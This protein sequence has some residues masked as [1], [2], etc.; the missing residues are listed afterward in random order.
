MI[1][2]I[3]SLTPFTSLAVPLASRAT[4]LA[5]ADISLHEIEQSIEATV[6]SSDKLTDTM[7]SAAQVITRLNEDVLS[8]EDI[9]EVIQ[10]IAEQTNLLALNAAIEAARAG[11]QG[12]GFAVVADEVRTLA[13]RTQQSTQEIREK[14]D[15][16]MTGSTD[17]V[18]SIQASE[19]NVAEVSGRAQRIHEMFEGYLQS[20]TRLS[21]LNLQVSAST[22]QQQA[23][24]EEIGRRTNGINDQ[25]TELA[26]RFEST[27][28]RANE[29]NN[30]A[31]QLNDA[32]A[33]IRL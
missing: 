10:K 2:C 29:L 14:I 32:I 25:G 18:N 27:S 7:R 5:V 30:I 23:T 12:R 3:V 26:A 16:V 8:I 21:E 1:P 4:S 20:V 31:R 24:S 28:E 6:T 33:I 17:A 15:R 22:E 19:H 11:E 13:S 9:L